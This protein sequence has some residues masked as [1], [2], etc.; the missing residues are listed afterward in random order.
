MKK[1]APDRYF[2]PEF[3]RKMLAAVYL[4]FIVSL[5]Y[6]AADNDTKLITFA[7]KSENLNDVLI[8]FKDQTGVDILFNKQLIGN[9]K[10]NDFEVVNQPV[11]VILSKILEGTGFVFSKVDGVYVIK[12]STE[13]I[14]QPVEPL[15]ISGVVTDTD[16]APLPGVTVLVKGTSLGSATDTEG[17]FKLSLPSQENVV[18]VFSFVGMQTKEVPYKG[19]SEIKVTLQTD[20][21]EMEQVVVTGIFTRKAESFTGAATTF[22]REDLKRLGNQNILQSLKN[23]D[24]SFIV[25]ESVDFGSDPN[26]MPDMQIRGASSLPNVKGDNASNPNQ[27]LFILDGFEATV[28][29]VFDLDMNRVAS[30]TL[31]KDAAAKAIYGSRAANGVVV[32]ETVQPEKGMLK[33]TYSGDLNIT[34]PDLSSY[35]LCNAAEKLQVEWDAGRYDAYLP[36]DDQF[37]LEEYNQLQKEIARGASPR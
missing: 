13:K 17:K 8:K 30:V 20:V 23:M 22:K 4:L 21:T 5:S 31:L 19:E 28:E 14:V 7:V 15:A 11:E 2:L 36:K 12:K 35:D 10:C 1:K 16:G 29:K 34:G 9:R 37:R 33:V 6:A 18:L 32:I 26:R 25:T 3:L 24:P 27:P